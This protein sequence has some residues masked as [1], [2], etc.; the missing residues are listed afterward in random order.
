MKM[1]RI[2]APAAIVNPD[3]RDKA[4]LAM[5]NGQPAWYLAERCGWPFPEHFSNQLHSKQITLTPL[6]VARF[7]KLAAVIQFSGPLFL[8][9]TEVD[10]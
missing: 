8:D 1:G 5:A 10:A 6:T 4:R 2:P 9:P 3:L 7:A